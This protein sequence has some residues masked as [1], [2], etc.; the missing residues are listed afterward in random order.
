[1]RSLE[2]VQNYTLGLAKNKFAEMGVKYLM[3]LVDLGE[4][5]RQSAFK[6]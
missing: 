2:S 4:D 3:Y 6:M 1:M 5:M